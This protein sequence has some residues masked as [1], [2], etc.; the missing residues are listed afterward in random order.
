M[1]KIEKYIK[2]NKGSITTV[3]LVTVLFFIT[4]LS[5]AYIV[6]ATLRK[7][8]LKSE[9][10]A[11]EVYEHDFNN[12]DTIIEDLRNASYDPASEGVTI[13]TGFYYVGGTKDSG[14]VISD[15][16][17]DENKYQ[18]QTT[19]GTDLA[20]NQY[21]WVEVPKTTTVYPTAG[22]GITTFNDT[23][24]ER[25]EEDLHTYTS[26]Y[27]N[28][29]SYTDTYYPDTDNTGWFTES[30]YNTAKKNMLKSVYENGGFYVGRYETGIAYDDANG[31]RNFGRDYTTLHEA[32]QTPVIKAN[33][34][35]YNWVRR[36]QAQALASSM[37]SGDRTSSLMF[38]VQWD[39]V[40]AFMKKK[41]RVE[42]TILTSD[43]TDI[44]NYANAK[45]SMTSTN[46]KYAICSQSSYTLGNWN[47]VP[48]N[49]EKPN[50]GT[51]NWVLLTTG[52]NETRNSKMNICD[53]AGNVWEWTLEKPYYTNNPCAYRGG[54][55]N[56]YGSN[57]PA[58]IRN[59]NNTTSSFNDLGFRVSLY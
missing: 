39:L 38:G 22:L 54:N 2:S 45:F 12:I 58:S 49:Y 35:P 23:A 9:V 20:G 29:T 53:L 50:S 57:L 24:Y 52:A 6:T 10:T 30:Q 55:Y 17:A 3:V 4:I 47:D 40:L 25:I 36:T 56:L 18:G 7:S 19:V 27:R 44:G 34:Y 16:S 33:A 28:G 46:A 5:T 11:K 8:Q 48:A 41:G 59:N 42:D 32:T 51:E 26:T 43:S 15:N 1:K 37:Y 14:L 31:P 21:V 13:P